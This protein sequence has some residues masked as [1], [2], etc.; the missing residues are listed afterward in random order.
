MGSPAPGS[1][2]REKVEEVDCRRR[3][4]APEE[5]KRRDAT[6][7]YV[8]GHVAVEFNQPG[9]PERGAGKTATPVA[10]EGPNCVAQR[11]VEGPE[12][13]AASSV[14]RPACSPKGCEVAAITKG[15]NQATRMA[16]VVC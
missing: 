6:G 5:D 11:G 10:E 14:G 3:R 1:R 9:V 2:A 7:V 15:N 16:M 8:E 12:L 13:V 4:R